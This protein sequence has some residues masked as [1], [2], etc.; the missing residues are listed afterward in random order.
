VALS[1]ADLRAV[2]YLPALLPDATVIGSIGSNTTATLF[3]YGNLKSTG[4]LISLRSLQFSQSATATAGLVLSLQADRYGSQLTPIASTLAF[5]STN[6]STAWDLK[7]GQN[8]LQALVINAGTSALT[9][10]GANWSIAVEAPSVAVK[11]VF[12]DL[13][14]QGLTAREQ[15][16]AQQYGL[17][18]PSP[19][20][21]L[22]R[23]LH[24]IVENEYR[25]QIVDAVVIGQALTSLPA[26]TEVLMG[27]EAARSGEM[28]VI[29]SLWSTQGSGTDGLT[30]V[31]Q[32]DDNK[33]FLEINA[34][35]LGVALP[36]PAFIQAEQQVAIYAL[37]NST[38]SNVVMGAE[39]WHVRLTD[40][41]RYR[42]G[43]LDVPQQVKDKIDAGVL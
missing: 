3:R 42:L 32:V 8:L 14:G 16:L 43:N 37:A 1:T 23:T 18:G 33:E 25:T 15:Q 39:V 6:P 20:G 22:P 11:T 10:V 13:V 29:R 28:L 12:G 24:W 4:R 7:A 2:K 21:V 19:R 41:I 35:G 9:N 34:Y 30:M 17:T 27:Q 31:V 26:G 5:T 38:V 36:A 40:E